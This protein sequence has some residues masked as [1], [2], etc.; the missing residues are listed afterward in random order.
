[1]R[2]P[3]TYPGCD[4]LVV[5]AAL[6]I[7]LRAAHQVAAPRPCPYCWGLCYP[8]LAGLQAHMRDFHGRV[9]CDDR[10]LTPRE[11]AQIARR[12]DRLPRSREEVSH[13]EAS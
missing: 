7:H 9:Q 13:A 11:V 12:L 10:W 1:M 5:L 6:E 8:D 4:Q 2:Q 3:C